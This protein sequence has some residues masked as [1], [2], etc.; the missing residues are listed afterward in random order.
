MCKVGLVLTAN[1]IC[2]YVHIYTTVFYG[3]D[4]SNVLTADCDDGST[5]S[6]LVPIVYIPCTQIYQLLLSTFT[7]CGMGAVGCQGLL[8]LRAPV[9]VTQH[10][11]F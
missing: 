4:M 10:A 8:A 6:I 1:M 11:P 3:S 5:S 2:S 7:A 9:P